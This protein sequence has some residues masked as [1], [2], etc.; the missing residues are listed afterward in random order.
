MI[1]RRSLRE[2]A[3]GAAQTVVEVVAD[4]RLV[5][6]LREHLGEQLERLDGDGAA[7]VLRRL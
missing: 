3:D 2:P 1:A 6:G 5:L 7:A 4:R